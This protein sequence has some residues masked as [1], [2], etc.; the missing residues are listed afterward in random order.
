MSTPN[1]LSDNRAIASRPSKITL[2]AD[3]QGW[4]TVLDF[5][6]VHFPYIKKAIWIERLANNKIHWLDGEFITQDTLFMPSKQL[7][8]YRE[9]PNEPVIPFEHKIVYQDEHILIACKP[10]FLQVTPGGIYVN[11]CLLER[12]RKENDLPDIVPLH[13]LDR[14]TAGLVMFSTNPH[15][16]SVYSQLFAT[17]N[18]Q[19]TYQAVSFLSEECQKGI[20]ANNSSLP[21]SWSIA[22]RLQKSTPK[23]IMHEVEGEINARSEITLVETKIDQNGQ[24]LGMFELNPITG[25]T[26]QLRLHMQKIG[27]PILNDKFYPTLLPKETV[28]SFDNPLQ[29]FAKK[30][31]FVDPVSTELKT[32]E[33]TRM[34][35]TWSK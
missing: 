22:N 24:S 29:L 35:D 2:P 10:H 3:N 13:R 11:E 23:F 21:M 31:T 17:T 19:K 15:T 32:F 28:L 16:R 6:I 8:Y 30:L 34:L 7:C 4:V 5:L 27:M 20:A 14:E 1:D 9:V 25:K 26:H 12:L 18:I 33:S